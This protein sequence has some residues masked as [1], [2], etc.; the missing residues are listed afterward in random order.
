MSTRSR[1]SRR[2]T[3]RSIWTMPSSRN[4]ARERCR[5]PGK[6]NKAFFKKS[7]KA[8]DKNDHLV[9][10]KKGILWYDADGSGNGA[11]VQ[12]RHDVEEAQDFGAGFHR[13]LRRPH[14]RP[15]A[16]LRHSQALPQPPRA[17]AGRSRRSSRSPARSRR[18]P[19]PR[20]GGGGWW[21]RVPGVSGGPR[22]QPAASQTWSDARVDSGEAIRWS[23]RRGSCAARRRHS[24]SNRQSAARRSIAASSCPAPAAWPRATGAAGR[25][26][27]I[28]RC[29]SRRSGTSRA[30]DRGSHRERAESAAAQRWRR[31]R[32]S[33]RSRAPTCPIRAPRSRIAWK[34]G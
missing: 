13:Y 30:A 34:S 29:L 20:G 2:P 14:R 22:R 31:C 32:R 1:I 21:T 18:G 4:S 19:R 26:R 33:G 3:T 10:D 25:R 27:G 15:M 6:L 5:V 23:R 11:A 9:Y 24:S 7:D 28:G 8:R 17:S 12:D 16:I